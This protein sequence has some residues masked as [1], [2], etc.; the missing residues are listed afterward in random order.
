LQ[1]QQ[2]LDFSRTFLVFILLILFLLHPFL[3]HVR[4]FCCL[5][6][7]ELYHITILITINT[8]TIIIT[9]TTIRTI[10]ATANDFN[11]RV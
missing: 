1:Q 6:S 8:T 9:T 7:R 5:D 2:P 10:V 4:S 11:R 3:L